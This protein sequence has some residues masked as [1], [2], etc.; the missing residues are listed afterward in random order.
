MS[1]VDTTPES[2]YGRNEVAEALGREP[3]LSIALDK[4]LDAGEKFAPR[5]VAGGQVYVGTILKHLL[6]RAQAEIAHERIRQREGRDVMGESFT[7]E[8]AE[9]AEK[10]T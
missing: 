10:N 2:G 3:D 4:F 9:N 6:A 1:G 7:A 8:N 5:L